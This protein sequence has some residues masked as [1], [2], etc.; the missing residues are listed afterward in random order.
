[1]HLL[2]GAVFDYRDAAFMRGPVD[3]NVLLHSDS[4]DLFKQ[5]AGFIQRQTHDA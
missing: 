5:L 3:K 4:P 1:M 2:Q